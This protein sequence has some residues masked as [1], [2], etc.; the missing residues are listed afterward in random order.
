MDLKTAAIAAK[1][2]TKKAETKADVAYKKSLEAN[3]SFA[4]KLVQDSRTATAKANIA[5]KVSESFLK[6]GFKS[7]NAENSSIEND[8]KTSFQESAD[9][10]K[11]AANTASEYVDAQLNSADLQFSSVIDSTKGFTTAQK[12]EIEDGYHRDM[13]K[14]DDQI[15]SF[16]EQLKTKSS[17][18][19]SEL[20]EQVLNLKKQRTE[21]NVRLKRLVH[22]N[23]S[24]WKDLRL[25]TESAFE[26]IKVSFKKTSSDFKKE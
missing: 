13:S 12:R 24:A 8:I 15:A 9:S 18:V 6:R 3:K 17:G 2:A 21:L 4:A 5:L 20:S 7:G 19:K 22:A 25:G 1:R 26:D 14:L 23:A 11:Q 10:T 16:D